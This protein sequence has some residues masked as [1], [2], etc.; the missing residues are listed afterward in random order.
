MARDQLST[1][2]PTMQ[3]WSENGSVNNVATHISVGTYH[4]A[5]NPPSQYDAD[6]NPDATS[7]EWSDEN[8]LVEQKD[9]DLDPSDAE[10][11]ED[12]AN[13]VGL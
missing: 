9:R 13:A 8:A 11:Q 7:K 1:I 6:S 10:Y 12:R 3:L 5:S 2:A 4:K